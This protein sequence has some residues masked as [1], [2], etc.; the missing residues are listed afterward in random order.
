MESQFTRF[1]TGADIGICF[2][3]NIFN[4]DAPTQYIAAYTNMAIL[5]LTTVYSSE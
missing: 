2:S 4:S 3:H 5:K 1:A